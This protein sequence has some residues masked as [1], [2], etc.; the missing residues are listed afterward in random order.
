M[1]RKQT[2]NG[3]PKSD[4]QNCAVRVS[5]WISTVFHD[6]IGEHS[7]WKEYRWLSFRYPNYLPVGIEELPHCRAS[8]PCVLR[9]RNL[10]CK[11]NALRLEHFQDNASTT[12]APNEFAVRSQVWRSSARAKLRPEAGIHVLSHC[13]HRCGPTGNS[14]FGHRM[15]PRR[16]RMR[17]GKKRLSRY[18]FGSACSCGRRVFRPDWLHPV[19]PRR[20]RIP[21]ECVTIRSDPDAGHHWAPKETGRF[22]GCCPICSGPYTTRSHHYDRKYRICRNTIHVVLRPIQLR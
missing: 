4:A 8:D 19:G 13:R 14:R 2:L 7:V 21:R 3:L 18:G 11:R 1:D 20:A 16:T 15:W 10:L 6:R 9:R 22:Y 5:L 17:T 12:P